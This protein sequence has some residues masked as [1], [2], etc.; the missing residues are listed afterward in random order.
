MQEKHG[1]VHIAIP[2]F[3]GK[4]N[5]EAWWHNGRFSALHPEGRRFESLRQVLHL[6]LPVAIRRVNSD[7]VSIL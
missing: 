5:I 6:Q 4:L 1:N 2:S 7:T 3:L